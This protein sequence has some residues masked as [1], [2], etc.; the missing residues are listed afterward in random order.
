ME[1]KQG[2]LQGANKKIFKVIL[3]EKAYAKQA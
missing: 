3:K 1:R 2:L